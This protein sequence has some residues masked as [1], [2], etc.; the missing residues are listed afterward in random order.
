MSYLHSLHFEFENFCELRTTNDALPP[1]SSVEEYIDDWV[2]EGEAY[3]ACGGSFQVFMTFVS[4]FL[5]WWHDCRVTYT[6]EK[7]WPSWI[8]W[9]V[10]RALKGPFD[11]QADQDPATGVF[12]PLHFEYWKPRNEA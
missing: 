9:C 8:P 11:A 2:T 7:S 3:K 4:Y 5:A 1:H 12:N 6:S 10:D